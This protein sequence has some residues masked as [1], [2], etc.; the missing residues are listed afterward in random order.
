MHYKM[1]EGT[2]SVYVHNVI[3]TRGLV[4]AQFTPC[5]TSTDTGEEAKWTQGIRNPNEFNKEHSEHE[6]MLVLTNLSSK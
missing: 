2:F 4:Y 3:M 5:H 1:D 6:W